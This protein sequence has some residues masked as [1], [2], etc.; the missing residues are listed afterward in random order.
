[1][2]SSTTGSGSSTTGVTSLADL[3]ERVLVVEAVGELGLG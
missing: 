2:A 3:A 1:M